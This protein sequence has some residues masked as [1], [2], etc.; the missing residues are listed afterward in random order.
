MLL[1]HTNQYVIKMSFSSNYRLHIK[2]FIG[3]TIRLVFQLYDDKNADYF[4]YVHLN[5][6]AVWA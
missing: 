6:F 1:P 4:P 5:V 3:L 2:S